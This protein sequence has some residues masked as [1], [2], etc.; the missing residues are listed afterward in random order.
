MRRKSR[1]AWFVAVSLGVGL[2]LGLITQAWAQYPPPG[3]SVV[4]AAADTTPGLG[5]TVAI[6]AT[7]QDEAGVPAAGVECTFSVAQQPGNDASVDA[8]PFTTDAAGN[9]STTLN[10][11]SADGTIVVE[12]ACGELSA[13]VS[14]VATA[15]A[16]EPPASLPETGT[17]AEAGGTGWAF[18][19]LIGAGV[20]VGLGGGLAVAW[21]RM[22]A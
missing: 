19:A 2:A 15:Q 18:W 8:G 3:G 20:V 1:G 22:K 10:T 14:V 21:R 13:Q 6:D 11:G 17:G 12:A 9:V 5:E 7:V 4:L 16:A